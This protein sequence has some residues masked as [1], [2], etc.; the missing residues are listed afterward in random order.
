MRSARSDIIEIVAKD[1][2]S[3]APRERNEFPGGKF[4]SPARCA[5]EGNRDG[6][7][8]GED[9]KNGSESAACQIEGHCFGARLKSV[10]SPP[11]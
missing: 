5:V 7:T 8:P 4:T 2:Y 6:A 10:R 11:G 9:N 3:T 1:G